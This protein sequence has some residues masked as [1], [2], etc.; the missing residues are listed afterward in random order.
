M[1]RDWQESLEEP[2]FSTATHVHG[3]NESCSYGSKSK[4]KKRNP[5]RPPTGFNLFAA[6]ARSIFKARHPRSSTIDI[7]RMIGQSWSDMNDIERRPFIERADPSCSRGMSKLFASSR[8]VE[9][10]TPGNPVPPSSSLVPSTPQTSCMSRANIRK[11]SG[12]SGE[13]LGEKGAQF[14]AQLT[15]DIRSM[16]ARLQELEYISQESPAKRIQEIEGPDVLHVH[17]EHSSIFD[18]EALSKEF[19][20]P[21]DQELVDV[22]GPLEVDCHSDFFPCMLDDLM[23]DECLP[24]SLFGGDF[25]G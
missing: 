21:F 13:P 14:L 15:K 1:K 22:P 8:K 12:E 18:I 20:I 11:Q 25:L 9:Q 5:R 10:L 7:E 6:E 4:K 23:E 17:Q 24:P 3:P 2:D 19:E 16:H